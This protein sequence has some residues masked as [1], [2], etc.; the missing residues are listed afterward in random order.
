MQDSMGA[1]MNVLRLRAG[2]R[3]G[4]I[5]TRCLARAGLVNI[6]NFKE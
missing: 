6:L 5:L 4:R 3:K 1:W 2:L